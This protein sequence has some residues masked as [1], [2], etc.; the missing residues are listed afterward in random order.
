KTRRR[1]LGVQPPDITNSQGL[2]AFCLGIQPIDG[3]IGIIGQKLMMDYR[4]V[5][6]M[7]NLKV[8]WSHSNCQD[9]SDG[10]KVHITP[11]PS[12][13]SPNSMPN[14]DQQSTPRPHAVALLP[15]GLPA[16]KVKIDI[17]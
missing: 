15:G 5:F 16:M 4:I 14:N 17:Y 1:S 13:K 8:V 10:K 11:P 6:D 7:E 12:D 3:G 2:A 9:V